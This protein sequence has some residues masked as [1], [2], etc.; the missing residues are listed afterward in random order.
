VV[1]DVL[2]QVL[3]GVGDRSLETA[4]P[5]EVAIA[6]RRRR[7]EQRGDRASAVSGGAVGR[8]EAEASGGESRQWSGRAHVPRRMHDLALPVTWIAVLQCA[9]N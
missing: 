5:V 2:V 7:A 4:A 6:M 9:W 8:G 3:R 1:V